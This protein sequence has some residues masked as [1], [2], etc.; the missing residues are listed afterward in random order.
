MGDA[1]Y[2]N[3]NVHTASPYVNPDDN[4]DKFSGQSQYF[5]NPL[6]NI[7]STQPSPYVQPGPDPSKDSLDISRKS[8]DASRSFRNFSVL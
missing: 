8:S 2:L 5:H 1:Q 3:N 6:G 7:Y 4:H